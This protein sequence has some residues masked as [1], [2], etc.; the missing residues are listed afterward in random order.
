MPEPI[1][2]SDALAALRQKMEEDRGPEPQ[3]ENCHWCGK[4]CGGTCLGLTSSTQMKT[5]DPAYWM[6]RDGH[7]STKTAHDDNCYIC[8]DPEF[9]QM[10]L[11]LCTYCP[12]CT[13]KEG[14]SAGH[15]PADDE[16]CSVCGANAREA[17]EAEQEQLKGTEA[18]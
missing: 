13:T 5:D 3:V 15:V 9:A 10:G 12:A 7:A 14:K 11:P 6:L 1:K 8:R 4:Q 17:Y 2:L 18:G 16:V